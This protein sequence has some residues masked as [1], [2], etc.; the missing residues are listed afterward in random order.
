MSTLLGVLVLAGSSSTVA[1]AQTAYCSTL[2]GQLYELDIANGSTTPLVNAGVNLLFGIANTGTPNELIISGVTAGIHRVDLTTGIV[3]PL[4]GFNTP[5]FA[6]CNNE[7]D[8]KIYAVSLGSLYEVDGAT[9]AATLIGPT[10]SISVWG[11]DY[12]QGLQ[13]LFGFSSITNELITINAATGVGTVVGP[14]MPGLVGLWYDRVGDK[15]YGIC[16]QNNAGCIS[17]I[18]VTTGAATLLHSTGMNLVGIGG[19]IGGGA[20]NMIGSNYCSA[21]AN[22]TGSPGAMWAAGSTSVVDND[23]TIGC[24]G[25]PPNQFGIFVAS[26]TQGLSIGASGSSNGDLCIA[27]QIGRFTQPNQILSTGPVGEFSLSIDL[28]AIPQG[29]VSVGVVAG[30]S[31]NFQAWH[32]DGVGLGSNFTDGLEISFL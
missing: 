25:L 26:T 5:M 32:R 1:S 11:L 23:V 14:T 2:G 16:D 31:W 27:G 7:D 18:N 28:T 3:T 8:G 24:E 6:L 9:G 30:Q 12:H 15:L 22:S 19:D 21:V 17:E 13:Q 20:P 4:P 29:G 10:G